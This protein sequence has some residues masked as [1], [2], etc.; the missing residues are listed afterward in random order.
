[1]PVYALGERVPTIHPDA[2]VHP[3]AVIIGSVEIGAESTVWPQA[4]LRGDYGTIR[5]AERTSVL[6]TERPPNANGGTTTT[7]NP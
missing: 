3:D 1:M 6:R 4:V 2:Y 5:I 7:S